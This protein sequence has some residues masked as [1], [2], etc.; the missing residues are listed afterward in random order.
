LLPTNCHRGM[1]DSFRTPPNVD[2]PI[3]AVDAAHPQHTHTSGEVC[4]ESLQRDCSNAPASPRRAE[5]PRLP[6]KTATFKFHDCI[7]HSVKFPKG[8]F[9]RRVEGRHPSRSRVLHFSAPA[10][11][12]RVPPRG[13]DSR[14]EILR[15][16][17]W[18][19]LG[20]PR[21][22]FDA[23]LHTGPRVAGATRTAEPTGHRGR[24]GCKPRDPRARR[25]GKRHRPRPAPRPLFYALKGLTYHHAIWHLFVL[26]G[27]V[28]FWIGIYTYCC[29]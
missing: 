5:R 6:F 16:T 23:A 22:K 2:T 24:G 13:G 29:G 15:R 9:E 25:R 14:G 27:S 28:F 12:P 21:G 1:R 26:G 8:I 3:F 10:S 20:G 17:P 19:M 7:P 4:P 11:G 18:G